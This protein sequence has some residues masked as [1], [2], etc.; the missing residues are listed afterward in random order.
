MSSKLQHS[1][2]YP[3]STQRLWEL[4][5]NEQ[6]WHD[7]IERINSSHGHI[8]SYTRDGDTVVVEMHQGIPADKLPS[9]V[10]KIKPGDMEIPRRNTFRLVG[11][12][13]EG[14]IAATVD[15]AP[16]NING[17][18]TTSGD[19][20]RTDYTADVAVSIPLLGGKIEKQVIGHL[21]DLLDSEHGHTVDWEQENRLT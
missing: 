5:T 12:T 17:T 20:A 16:V 19:P 1:V 4:V 15:G 7:L 2:T 3:F 8:D 14:E 21:I 18:L 13:I 10:T 11:D 9:G 6:Y